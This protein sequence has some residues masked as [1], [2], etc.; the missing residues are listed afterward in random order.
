MN[1]PSDLPQPII[2]LYDEY[3]HAP[4]D[5]RVFL[6][7]LASLAGSSAAA[8]ALLPL[9]EN[10]YAHAA[11]VPESDVRLRTQS[12][13]FSGP[14]GALKAYLAQPAAKGKRG[15]VLVIHENRGLNPHIRDVARRTALAGYNA[16]ALDFLSP[17]GGTPDNEDTARELFSK[18]NRAETANNGIAALNA[19]K[20]LPE[21]NGRIGAVGFCW[22]GGMVNQLAVFEPDLDA[23]VCFYGMAPESALVPQIKARVLL[24]YAGQDERINAGREAFESALKAANVRFESFLYEGKQHAFHNDTNTARYDKAAADLAWNRTLALFSKTLKV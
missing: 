4:L 1:K 14:K 3:T 22:G 6:K 20:A 21:S 19:L 16:L 7:Q 23:A 24:H 2:N 8:Y 17:L 15:S 10:N 12:I 5:R 13:E 18:L 9:L 11:L